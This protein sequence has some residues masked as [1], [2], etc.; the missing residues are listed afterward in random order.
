MCKSS[1]REAKLRVW[2]CMCVNALVLIT[3]YLIL[4]PWDQNTDP[5]A[6]DTETDA[7]TCFHL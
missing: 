3:R 1:Q 2:V 7:P 5:H 6:R 4:R